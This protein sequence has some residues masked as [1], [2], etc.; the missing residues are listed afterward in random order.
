MC[1]M[2]SVTCRLIRGSL[3]Y[4]IHR[5]RTYKYIKFPHPFPILVKITEKDILDS[6]LLK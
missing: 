4:Y 3:F 5:K 6:F 1:E 2:N